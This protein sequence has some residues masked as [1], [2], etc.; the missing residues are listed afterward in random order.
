MIFMMI[1]SSIL[2][3]LMILHILEDFD[4]SL[5]FKSYKIYNQISHSHRIDY[6]KIT[7]IIIKYILM[8]FAII[9]C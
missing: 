2:L 6:M 1:F 8:I 5:D 7:I 4:L 9:H 3:I